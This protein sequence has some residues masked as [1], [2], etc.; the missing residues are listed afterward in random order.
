MADITMEEAAEFTFHHTKDV[1]VNNLIGKFSSRAIKSNEKHGDTINEVN[2]T[3][4]QWVQEGL[5]EAM[6]M[7]V[8]LQRLEE[9]IEEIKVHLVDLGWETQRMSSDGTETL[10]TL[11]E[12]F[13]IPWDEAIDKGENY[14]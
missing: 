10:K 14:G 6:D 2:K 7:C 1:T 5:E 3:V 4:G 12:Y 8:Y 9:L 11:W 13:G